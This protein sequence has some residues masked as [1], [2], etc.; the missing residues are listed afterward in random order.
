[1]QFSRGWATESVDRAGTEIQ[2]GRVCKCT[3]LTVSAFLSW[4]FFRPVNIEWNFNWINSSSF[5]RLCMRSL[6]YW[7]HRCCSYR[8][9]LRSQAGKCAS[10]PFIFLSVGEV[11]Q[12]RGTRHRLRC[13]TVKLTGCHLRLHWPTL[14]TVLWILALVVC[15]GCFSNSPAIK[16]TAGLIDSILPAGSSIWE[17]NGL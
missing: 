2:K 13:L 14:V 1:M 6:K 3:W 12:C 10:L 4:S 17:P 5:G 8:V 11:Q 16:I 9:G 15:P 7:M